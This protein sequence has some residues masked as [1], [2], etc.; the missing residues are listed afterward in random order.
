MWLLS[1]ILLFSDEPALNRTLYI[2]YDDSNES[3]F[4]KSELT[5]N[6]LSKGE[7]EVTLEMNNIQQE[8]AEKIILIYRYDLQNTRYRNISVGYPCYFYG[9]YGTPEKFPTETFN[10]VS[11]PLRTTQAIYSEFTTDLS[12]WKEE[13]KHREEMAIW[14]HF[15]EVNAFIRDN[16][17]TEYEKSF[18]S[19]DPEIENWIPWIERYKILILKFDT[20]DGFPQKDKVIP[21]DNPLINKP[22]ESQ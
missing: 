4:L 3:R 10:E 13:L 20:Y 18:E 7:S 17:P 19:S 21:P 1:L 12:S 16:F 8:L 9:E 14:N 15:V 22:W 2:V 5:R 6:W 11:Y